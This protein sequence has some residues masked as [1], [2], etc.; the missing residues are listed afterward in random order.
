MAQLGLDPEQ[1]TALQKAFQREATGIRSLGK[2]LDGQLKAAWW[3][4]T[5]ADKFRAEWDGSHKGQLEKIAASLEDAA[6]RIGSNVTQQTQA[7]QA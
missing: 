1:M 5:D 4:G 6:K 3:K 2:Q 7:S